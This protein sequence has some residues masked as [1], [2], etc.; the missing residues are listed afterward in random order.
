MIVGVLVLDCLCAVFSCIRHALHCFLE[1]VKPVG[2]LG[3]C[4]SVTWL[5]IRSGDLDHNN[6]AICDVC[7]YNAVRFVKSSGNVRTCSTY[8]AS[9]VCEIL[10][11]ICGQGNQISMITASSRNL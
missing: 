8:A 2:T 4:S 6:R 10:I 5:H 1:R 3:P 9:V 7:A 11:T